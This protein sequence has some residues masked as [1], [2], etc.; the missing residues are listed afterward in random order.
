M[1]I[2]KRD[3]V[4]RADGGTSQSLAILIVC[5][6]CGAVAG[7][8]CASYLGDF[9]SDVLGDYL[10]GY[11]TDFSAGDSVTSLL[12]SVLLNVF[13]YPVISFLFGFTMLGVFCVPACAALRGFFAAFSI[14]SVIK[15]F[16]IS[17]LWLAMSVFGIQMLFGIPCFLI[18]SSQSFISAKNFTK[19]IAGKKRVMVGSFFSRGYFV[20]FGICVCVLMVLVLLE[21]FLVPKLVAFT[22]LRVLQ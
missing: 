17:G 20:L 1:K 16:G 15:V 22:A 8:F 21:L 5:L 2:K 11:V 19:M 4:R 12:P 14:G 10:S 7:A 18:I 9:S 6:L 3:V 13:K